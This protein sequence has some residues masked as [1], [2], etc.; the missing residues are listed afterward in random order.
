[1]DK[2]KAV[3]DFLKNKGGGNGAVINGVLVWLDIQ[4][5]TTAEDIFLAQALS[6]FT[7]TEIN[8]AKTALWSVAD[9]SQI[10]EYSA[11]RGNT[12]KKNELDDIVKAMKILNDKK[13]L[14]LLVGTSTMMKNL[15]AHNID[16]KQADTGD[17]LTRMQVLEQSMACLLYTS[18]SPR[19][20]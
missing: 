7:D 4:I 2:Y 20:S 15:P 16:P 17:I 13:A 10:G 3:L 6:C 19:D 5:K 11:R 9:T 12:K 14:P 18:P 1:M 8:E